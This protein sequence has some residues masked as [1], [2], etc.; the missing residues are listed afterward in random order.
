MLVIAITLTPAR[1]GFAADQQHDDI[2]V[3]QG[4]RE[5]LRSGKMADPTRSRPLYPFLLKPLMGFL[6]EMRKT[7]KWKDGVPQPEISTLETGNVTNVIPLT[8][9]HGR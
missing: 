1:S 7:V 3:W 5:A 4:F 8:F 6:E 2:Q 9:Q